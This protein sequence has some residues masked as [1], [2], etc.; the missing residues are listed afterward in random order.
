M[1]LYCAKAETHL[2]IRN[3]H[4]QYTLL[5]FIEIKKQKQKQEEETGPSESKIKRCPLNILIIMKL[6]VTGTNPH[7]S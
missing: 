3:C 7:N 1:Y 2:L 6:K 4:Y 5:H